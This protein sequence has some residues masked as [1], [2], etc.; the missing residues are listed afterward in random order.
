MIG[1]IGGVG[2]HDIWLVIVKQRSGL[3]NIAT[4]A[5]CQN[6]PDWATKTAHCAVN[7]AA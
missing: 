2:H 5:S 1:I 6:D 7:F 3:R 4:V